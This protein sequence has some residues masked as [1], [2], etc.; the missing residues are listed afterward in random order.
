MKNNRHRACIHNF[1]ASTNQYA[2]PVS[3]QSYFGR[4]SAEPHLEVAVLYGPHGG[5]Q[6]WIG[7]I[8]PAFQHLAV[9][10][11]SSLRRNL[12]EVHVISACLFLRANI[13]HVPPCKCEGMSIDPTANIF[14]A[15]AR[16]KDLYCTV[17][18]PKQSLILHAGYRQE[19]TLNQV[20]SACM[21]AISDSKLSKCSKGAAARARA[22]SLK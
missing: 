18:A 3:L 15:T 5:C 14:M 19:P 10:G 2:V 16:Q 13:C 1:E 12:V 17:S 20:I 7:Q 21:P 8:K 9:L 11:S 6:D 4:P 22:T